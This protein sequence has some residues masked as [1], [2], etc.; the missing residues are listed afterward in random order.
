MSN[1]MSISKGSQWGVNAIFPAD[2]PIARSNAELRD[3]VIGGAAT[4]GLQGGDLWRT[5]GGA[6]AGNRLQMNDPENLPSHFPID[7]VDVTI[8]DDHATRFV[9]HLIGYNFTRNRWLAAMNVDF[10]RSYQLGPHAHPGDGLIDVYTGELRPGELPKVAPRAKSGTH[11][12]H[13]RICLARSADPLVTLRTPLRLRA[14]DQ[15]IGRGRRLQFCVVP[16]AITVI[17]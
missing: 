9:T 11:V 12:P 13:P 7:V 2:T 17:V 5:V 4:I 8:D 16:D 1:P 10:W 14:D 6:S 3:L 15:C